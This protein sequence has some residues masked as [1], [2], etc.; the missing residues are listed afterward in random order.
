MQLDAPAAERR[1]RPVVERLTRAIVVRNGTGRAVP[2]LNSN[3]ALGLAVDGDDRE[4]VIAGAV[5]CPAAVKQGASSL[6]TIQSNDVLRKSSLPTFSLN[7]AVPV[8]TDDPDSYRAAMR[9]S[10]A[11]RGR[12]HRA[13]PAGD[14]IHPPPV[15]RHPPRR[16]RPPARSRASCHCRHRRREP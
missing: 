9:M 4:L 14:A 6:T 2:D 15:T 11:R 16:K 7:S 1:D 10:I 8:G 3:R 5:E 12:C 13:V